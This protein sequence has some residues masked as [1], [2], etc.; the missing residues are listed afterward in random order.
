MISW[1]RSQNTGP[2]GNQS[3]FMAAIMIE[4]QGKEPVALKKLVRGFIGALPQDGNLFPDVFK[5][6]MYLI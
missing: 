3:N 1:Y 6:L 5:K 2:L 4:L